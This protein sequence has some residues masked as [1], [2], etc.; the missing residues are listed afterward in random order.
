MKFH[1]SFS[2]TCRKPSALCPSWLDETNTYNSKRVT[3]VKPKWTFLTTRCFFL[4]CELSCSKE[5]SEKVFLKSTSSKNPLK[6][7]EQSL[8]EFEG[9]EWM[10]VECE[11]ST[12]TP[13]PLFKEQMAGH[14]L[15]RHASMASDRWRRVGPLAIG[16]GSADTTAEP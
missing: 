9:S 1:P 13:R 2:W 12:P 15:E 5:M 14:R 8:R 6:T 4:E 16:V 11:S 3:L 7:R 10:R